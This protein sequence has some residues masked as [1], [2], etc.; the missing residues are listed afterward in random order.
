ML[1]N[2]WQS[3]RK[4]MSEWTNAGE[5]GFHYGSCTVPQGWAQSNRSLCKVSLTQELWVEARDEPPSPS[6]MVFPPLIDATVALP[7][8]GAGAPGRINLGKL[9]GVFHPG[10][11]L[12]GRGYTEEHCSPASGCVP[13]PHRALLCIW[14]HD[15]KHSRT[16]AGPPS[17]SSLVKFSKSIYKQTAESDTW[18]CQ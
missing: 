2:D 16:A 6:V 13:S 14:G 17:L 10:P 8:R 12:A 11:Q 7:K 4:W 9:D 1:L 15:N 18:I 3:E 5:P